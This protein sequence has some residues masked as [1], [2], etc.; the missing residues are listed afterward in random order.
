MTYALVPD[1]GENSETQERSAGSRQDWCPNSAHMSKYFQYHCVL[2][3]FFIVMY[4]KNS[5]CV[6]IK[7]FELPLCI[8]RATNNGEESRIRVVNEKD[9]TVTL[10]HSQTEV[11]KKQS[12]VLLNV[13]D[14]FSSNVSG[15]PHKEESESHI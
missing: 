11:F 13:C 9:G 2:L 5:F 15:E 1:D 6:L 8:E 10:R 12:C 14:F 7:P 3:Y 4:T